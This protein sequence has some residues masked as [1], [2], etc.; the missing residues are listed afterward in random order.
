MNH[1][2]NIPITISTAV[3]L[4]ILETWE[5]QAGYWELKFR[6][7][8]YNDGEGLDRM[9]TSIQVRCTD[10]DGLGVAVERNWW[11]VDEHTVVEGLKRIIAGGVVAGGFGSQVVAMLMAETIDC[12][13][14]DQADA[15]VQAGLFGKLVYC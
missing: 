1:D 9:L 4:S 7:P 6:K 5:S 8:A 11:I 12:C 10:E 3:C 14:V 2:L 15:I 13:D